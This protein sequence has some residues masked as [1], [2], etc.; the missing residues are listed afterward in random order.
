MLTTDALRT[1]LADEWGL[2][3]VLL[4]PH[5]RGMNSRTWLVDD[6]A[7]RWVAKAVPTDAGRRFAGGLAVATLVEAAGIPAGAPRPATD[8]RLV[9]PTEDAM[10]GLLRYVP[11]DELE[12]RDDPLARRTIGET[13]GRAHLALR[14]A[15]TADA[16]RFHWLD[17]AAPHLDLRDWLRPGITAALDA[18][19]RIPPDSMTWGLLHSDPAP[20]AFRLDPATGGCG[21]I[22]WDTAL[23]GPLMY[24]VASAVM[25]V[26]GPR[27]AE[28]L[29]EA[30]S[31]TNALDSS[32]IERTL[33]AMLRVRW[34]V[35][36]DYFA[37]RTAANDLTG[38]AGPEENEQGLEDA[39]R[40]LAR[41]SAP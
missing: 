29:L 1:L 14:G 31:L 6:G 39:R 26:G 3:G 37:R 2:D 17:V 33:R 30:Y 32:E 4:T 25:Y 10:V 13:L 9:V 12:D 18:Y 36:A 19:R 21:V 34:A 24:D 8:G 7:A 23:V 38:I 16:D 41:L 27:R 40:A 11:G 35:Q 15:A 20:E 28:P 22:D 5:D